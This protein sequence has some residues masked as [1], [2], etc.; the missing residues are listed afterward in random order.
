MKIYTVYD[1]KATS[2]GPLVAYNSDGEAVRALTMAMRDKESQLSQ[3]PQ[4]FN[5]VHLGE[6]DNTTGELRTVDHRIVVN[7][8]ALVS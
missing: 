3:F 8:S 6:W 1:A 2:F 7:L 4:D 5:L